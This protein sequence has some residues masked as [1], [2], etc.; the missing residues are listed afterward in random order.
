MGLFDGWQPG[1]KQAAQEA[2]AKRLEAERAKDRAWREARRKT[3]GIGQADEEALV[4]R[5][6]LAGSGGLSAPAASAP[7]SS[8]YNREQYVAYQKLVVGL[9]VADDTFVETTP[10][11]AEALPATNP[12]ATGE[13]RIL[14]APLEAPAPS[15]SVDPQMD[16]Y[17]QQMM[18]DEAAAQAAQY[19]DRKPVEN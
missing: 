7:S 2:E 17:M 5:A 9:P 11:T 1:R 13:F 16:G 19:Q 3:E 14:R 4:P 6:P 15:D 18:A 12:H 8:P 10:I